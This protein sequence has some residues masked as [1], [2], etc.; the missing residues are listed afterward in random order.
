MSAS[1][2]ASGVGNP[3]FIAQFDELIRLRRDVR[4]FKPTS[5]EEALVLEVIA[6]TRFAP[7]VGLSEPTRL[8]RLQS[9]EIRAAVRA[10]FEA[11]NA[12][13]LAGYHGE[14][15][16]KYAGLKLAGLT[17][18]PIQ[19]AVYCDAAT[20]QGYGL[21]AHTMPETKNY[22]TACAVM[23]MWLAA[24][25]RGLGIGWVSI[26]DVA[27]L[28]RLLGANQNWTFMGC[29]CIGRPEEQHFDP[30]LQRAGW[31]ARRAD[32]PTIITR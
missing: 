2:S 14:Q 18:A 11:A 3:D 21:G 31:Q 13:A 10:N 1:F 6:A 27:A 15:A 9:E 4:R 22:S 16:H 5:V 26:F 24:A 25:A 23:L 19:L 20:E 32:G 17:E 28:N 7:S 8:M 30:E 12:K 29:L